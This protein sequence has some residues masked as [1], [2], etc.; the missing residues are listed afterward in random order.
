LHH[1]C[2]QVDD[3]ERDL[4]ELKARGVEMIDQV[5]R[6]GL[7]GHICFLHPGAMDGALIELCQPLDDPAYHGVAT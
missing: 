1:I 2:F 6:V 4:V 5:T 3:V 7:A